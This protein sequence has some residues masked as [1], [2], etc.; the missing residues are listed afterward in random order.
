MYEITEQ[1]E[2][3]TALRVTVEDRDG[4]VGVAGTGGRE[5]LAV[6][7]LRLCCQAMIGYGYAERTVD[8]A[9][10]ELSERVRDD[11]RSENDSA[12]DESK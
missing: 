12:V 8:D 11:E 6:D 9:V 3:K 7:V 1:A 10:M 2:S 4:G 5:S